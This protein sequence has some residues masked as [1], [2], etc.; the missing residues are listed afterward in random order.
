[1]IRSWQSEAVA[2]ATAPLESAQVVDGDVRTGVVSLVGTTGLD[3]GVWEHSVGTSTDVEVDEVFVVIAGRGTVT[4]T[5]GG[6]IELAPGVVGVLTAGA[7]TTWQVTETLRKV[8]IT[9]A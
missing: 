9:P 7:Q 5:D 3:V 8:W 4:D 1:M 6:V 2:V